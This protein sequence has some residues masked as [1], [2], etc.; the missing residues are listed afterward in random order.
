[1]PVYCLAIDVVEKHVLDGCKICF[2]YGLW[3]MVL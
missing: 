1:M 2:I 3:V